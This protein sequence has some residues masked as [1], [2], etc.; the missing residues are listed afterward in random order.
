MSISASFILIQ[1]L[2]LIPSIIA[3]TSLQT[4]NRKRILILQIGCNIIWGFHYGLLGAFTAVMTNIVG[5]LRAVLCYHNDKKWAKSK[6]WVAL[7]MVL[8]VVSTI[9]TWDGWYCALPCFSMMLTTIALWTHNMKTTRLLFVLNSP[10]LLVYNILTGSYSCAF[11]EVC[12]FISFIIAVYRFD[13]R[14][15]KRCTSI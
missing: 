3:F 1:L 13:I 4:N 7:L 12:A 2:G 14:K 6:L 5:L 10:P 11:I 8:Y 15:Q 9:F